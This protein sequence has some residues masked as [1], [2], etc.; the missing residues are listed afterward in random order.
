[1]LAE[2]GGDGAHPYTLTDP[3]RGAD[4]RHFAQ[5]GGSSRKPFAGGL[6]P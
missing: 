2:L 4:M 3:D 6:A 1:V 5:I